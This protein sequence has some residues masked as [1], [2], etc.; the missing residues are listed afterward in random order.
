MSGTE[1]RR[2]GLCP[3]CDR[4]IGPATACP[5]CEA[6]AAEVPV[7]RW[8]RHGAWILAVAGL[9]GLYFMAKHRDYPVVKVAEIDSA[10]NFATVRV[11]GRVPQDAFVSKQPGRS[12]YLAFTVDDG[13]GQLRVSAYGPVAQALVKE[14]RVPR[15]GDTADA[16][17]SI[18]VKAGE[19]VKLR[20][21]SAANLTL[22][23]RGAEH[24][25]PPAPRTRYRRRAQE[26]TNGVAGE[27]EKTPEAGAQ[28]D[29]P[30]G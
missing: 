1:N 20:L 5:Y 10:M 3:S 16:V 8:L 12:D 22:K 23:E 17:G 27:A 21:Q 29:S 7:V 25:G 19:A 13:S 11:I 30:E 6:D 26:Q 9:A 14:N 15:R 18:S 2:G 4:F 24:A 28:R